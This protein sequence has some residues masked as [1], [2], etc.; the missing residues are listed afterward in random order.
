MRAALVRLDRLGPL[1]DDPLPDG[2]ASLGSSLC[3][4][5]AA[6]A[7]GDVGA[8][9]AAGAR[10]AELEGPESPWR[11]VATWSLGW[12]HY[13]NGELDLAERWLAETAALAPAADQWIVGTG[14]IAD[15]SLIAGLRGRH[16]EQLRLAT[17]AVDQARERG[18]LEAREVGE[19]HTAHGVA[20]AAH[21]RREE[22]L[23][24]LEQGVFLRRL[25]GQPLD[26]A[27][28]LIALAA[29]TAGVGDRERAAA[30]FAE[31]EALLGGCAD[32]GVLPERLAAA[33]RSRA[34]AGEAEL[35]ER[36]REV[37][38]LL[39]SGLSEREIA[40]ELFLSFN[41]VHSHVKSVYRKLGVSS[42]SAAVAFH[43]G[44]TRSG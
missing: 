12:G 20:L 4:L 18:L 44:E 7:W 27:D 26:L 43:L 24:A 30:L 16:A 14:A 38:A 17:A 9:L 21:G 13:C 23:P 3:V 11:P 40:G 37:L 34:P 36:E 19:V 15:L 22:A 28:G 6:F 42:R 33:R 5:S 2:F 31:A 29:G 41:T 35:S 25:W 39:S 1:A 10:S 8:S 32:P